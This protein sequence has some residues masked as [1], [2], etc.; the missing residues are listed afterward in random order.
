M[1]A[2]KLGQLKPLSGNLQLKN[3]MPT[4][5]ILYNSAGIPIGPRAVVTIYRPSATADAYGNKVADIIGH[6]AGGTQVGLATNI[7]NL[8]LDVST[9]EVGRTG[10]Y[11]EDLGD[12]SLVRQNPKL[13]LE[14]FVTSTGSPSVMPGDFL[15]LNVGYAITSTA[16]APVP[17][18]ASRW[19]IE[20]VNL[21]TSGA[22]KFSMKCSLDRPNSSPALVEF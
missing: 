2:A 6:G 12:G 7:E 8:S 13:S 14:A 5:V 4:P 21:T 11:G 1:R 9:K 10:I 19:K 17:I 3:I 16:A 20:S 22:N 15:D 18:A